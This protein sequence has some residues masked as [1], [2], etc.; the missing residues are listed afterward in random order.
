MKCKKH[1]FQKDHDTSTCTAKVRNCQSCKEDTHHV[2]LC[3]K[4]KTKTNCA[5]KVTLVGKLGLSTIQM[6]TTFV[7]SLQGIKLGTY[8]DLG[9]SDNYITRMAKRLGLKGV[10]IEIQ[11]EGIKRTTHMERTKL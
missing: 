4:V 8:W 1:L 9:N 5:I 11:M 10:D 6:Q 3:P 7:K 2:L